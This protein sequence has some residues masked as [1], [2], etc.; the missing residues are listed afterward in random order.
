M[1]TMRACIL[2]GFYWRIDNIYTQDKRLSFT[3]RTRLVT[4]THWEGEWLYK[5]V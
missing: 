2:Q 4:P 1:F 5:I 3:T